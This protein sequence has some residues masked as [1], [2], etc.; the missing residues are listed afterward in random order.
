MLSARSKPRCCVV[1]A[2]VLALF[3]G[4]V[5]LAD[6]ASDSQ[7][8][9][10]AE[11]ETKLSGVKLVGYSTDSNKPPNELRDDSYGLAMVKHLQGDSWLV[12]AEFTYG[13]KDLVLPLTL[14]IRWAGD[15]PVISLDKFSVPGL[16]T[17][18]ARVMIYQDHYAGFWSG[19]GHS[20]HVFGAVKR[21]AT[22]KAN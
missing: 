15:T 1:A 13:G 12:Q 6:D 14:P 18:D 5:A 10:F 11:L 21:A 22:D 9:R 17:F 8:K 3:A 20:G 16:G 7:A 4:R 19:A 2:C